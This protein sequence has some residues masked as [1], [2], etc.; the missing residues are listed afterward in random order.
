METL[1]KAA[2]LTLAITIFVW[3]CHQPFAQASGGLRT[4]ALTGEQAPGLEASINFASI[5]RAPA[6]NNLGRTAFIGSLRGLGIDSANDQGVWSEARDGELAL[7]AQQGDVAPGANGALLGDFGQPLLS[8]SGRSV[9]ISSFSRTISYANGYWSDNASGNLELVVRDSRFP[10]LLNQNGHVAYNSSSRGLWTDRGGSGF[11]LIVANYSPIDMQRVVPGTGGTTLDVASQP[12]LNSNGQLAFG[13]S[14]NRRPLDHVIISEETDGSLRLVMVEGDEA[15]GTGGA[16]FD[17]RRSGPALNGNGYTAFFRVLT[18]TG[19]NSSN[20]TGIWSEGRG[21]GLELVA[22]KGNEAPD[23][24]GTVFDRLTPPVL[25]NLGQTAFL[26]SLTGDGVDFLN[27]TGLW[28]QQGDDNEL[29]LVA[30]EGSPAP[31]TGGALFGSLSDPVLNSN[32]QVAFFDSLRGPGVD[33][34]NDSSIWAQDLAGNLKLIA[35]DG[36]LL[37]VSDDPAISDFRTVRSLSFIVGSGND[38][39]RASGF[40]DLGQLAFSASFTDGSQGI[41]VSDLVAVPEPST[42]AL[43]ALAATGMLCRRQRC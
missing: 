12:V 40:N 3:V 2:F 36:D 22:R 11:E 1:K 34:R 10:I 25:N 29:S 13:G 42:I 9:F 16:L 6:L 14:L 33:A 27:D 7:I 38:D 28:S 15:P 26:G 39:G 35:R 32:G 17:H 43:L 20:D 41:F 23:S 31:G 24:D 18:G 37:D 5:L 19:V 8:D 30:R 4:V 21:N